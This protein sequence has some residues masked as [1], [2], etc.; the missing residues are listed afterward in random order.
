MITLL[1]SLAVQAPNGVDSAELQ[2]LSDGWLVVRVVDGHVVHRG[3]GQKNSD[4]KAVVRRIDAARADRPETWT[5]ASTD[6]PAYAGGRRPSRVGRKTQGC[7]FAGIVEGW[8]D[9]RTVNTS[10][11]HALEHAIYLALPSPLRR[12]STYSVACGDLLPGAPP[13]SLR[14][15]EAMSRS[16][17][18]HVNLVGYPAASPAKFGYVYHWM[19]DA[20]ALEVR[21][22]D[23]RP[24]RLVDR[25]SGKTAFTGALKFRFAKEQP[26]TL[27]AA[28]SPPHGN[29]LK[30]DVLE[31]DFSRFAGEGTYVLA[32]DGVGCSFP[33]RIAKDAYRDAFRTTVRGLYHNRS[34]IALTKPHTEFER[35][36]PHNPLVTPGFKGKLVYTTS[37][38][39]DWK[40]GDHDKADVPAIEAGITG[41]LEAWGWYQDAG[42]WD[43]YDAHL[44][45]PSVLLLA[46][47][48]APAN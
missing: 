11:D 13:L 41:P 23:G 17:A 44:N 19:G 20:G 46:W 42:D 16:E 8:K 37:R 10:P 5:I 14:Y 24:F 3:K 45:V 15:D 21:P 25:P 26:E 33:F 9:G 6:D 18:V 27:H 31:A 12:G 32:V 2:A 35:P 7:D 40:S 34:G 30:A 29:F 39:V 43:S 48:L 4:E 1:L 38:F 28:D 47:E 36:A 22:L